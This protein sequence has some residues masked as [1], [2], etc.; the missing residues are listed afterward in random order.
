MT[1]LLP[2]E[3][4]R[5]I[6]VGIS[7]SESP[8]LAR[9][10]LLEA[11]FRLALGEIARVVL[12]SG[13]G[14]IYGG[15]LS[16]EGYTAFLAT[17]LQRYGRRDRPLLVCL[18]WQE[19]RLLPLSE[20]ER[21]QRDLGL[22]GRVVYLDP[23]GA[24]V[25]PAAGRDETPILVDDQELRQRALTGLRRYM[26]DRQHGRVLIGGQRQGFQ[27]ELPGLMQEAVLALEAHQPVY[28]AGGF[29]GVTVD[30]ARALGVDD[31]SWLPSETTALDEDQRLTAGY[32]RLQ[33]LAQAPKWPGLQNGLSDDENRR[34]A[35]SHRP[36]DIATLVSLGLGRL[37]TR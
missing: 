17:E 10:G 30:I 25:D 24:E 6:R 36:S 11:H 37:H 13:G 31:G 8:D 21:R 22:F 1:V 3:A 34:L 32:T 12:V 19:H 26:R 15:H 9:L 33:A 2:N 16:P 4:L 18:S 29:G 7:V 35:V 14:L 27:G 28:L 5:G 20:L 23:D